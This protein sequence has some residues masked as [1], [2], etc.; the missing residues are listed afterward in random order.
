MDDGHDPIALFL[1]LQKKA[2]ST[3]THAATAMMLATV[4]A[5]GRPSAR[6]VLLK[7]ASASG[8]VFYTNLASRKAKELAE[9][10][11]A[12]LVFHWPSVEQ[13]V[14]VEG[15]VERVSD[16]EADAYFATRPRGSQIGAWAS[17]QS[18]RL[19]SRAE[20][21]GRVAE[22]EARFA[23]E[24]VTRPPFWSGFRVVPDRIE[25]WQG[26]LDRLHERRVFVKEGGA[27]RMELLYP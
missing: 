25:L 13:Q 6:M 12:A 19:E 16:D 27:W 8:F 18:E 20:L 2:S 4:G 14:R 22:I 15:A 21:E 17:R 3:E 26:K 10:P 7:G 1:D 23:G 24:R 5:D 9:K 11:L